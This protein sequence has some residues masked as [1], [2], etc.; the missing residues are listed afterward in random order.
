MKSKHKRMKQ[1]RAEL[2]ILITRKAFPKYNTYVTASCVVNAL[3]PMMVANQAKFIAAFTKRVSAPL[4]H[5]T[6]DAVQSKKYVI[7]FLRRLAHYYGNFLAS[8]RKSIV[9]NGRTMSQYS[10]AL[11]KV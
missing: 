9:V 10:Y 6:D 8:K 5:L 11:V 7:S 4:L 3:H 1:K 2:A